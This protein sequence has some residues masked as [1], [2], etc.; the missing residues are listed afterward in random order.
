[1]ARWL[2]RVAAFIARLGRRRRSG[3]GPEDEPAGSQRVGRRTARTIAIALFAVIVTTHQLTPY[4]LIVGLGV[5]TFLGVV[6]PRL[7]VVLFTAMALAYLLPRLDFIQRY[8]GCW[9]RPGSRSRMSAPP[10]AG[11]TGWPGSRAGSC[12][13]MPHAC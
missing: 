6:R 10:P 13:P 11:S 3:A 7:L 1:M 8:Y 5:L 4:M 12:P 9:G 2:N